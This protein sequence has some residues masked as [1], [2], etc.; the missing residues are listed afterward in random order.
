MRNAGDFDKRI[1][2]LHPVMGEDEGFGAEVTWKSETVWAQ[3][4]RPRF[5]ASAS[6]GSG[7][8]VFIT[9]GIRIRSRYVDKGWR[10]KYGDREM[11]ILHIDDSVKG[12]L[13]LTCQEI[14]S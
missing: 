9:Q 11:K 10:V 12:E 8:A 14:Q 1:S 2:L 5:S 6:L 7:D 3:F 13:T 4:L